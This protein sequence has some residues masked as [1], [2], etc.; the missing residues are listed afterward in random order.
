MNL[1]RSAH[2][3]VLGEIKLRAAT[4]TNPKLNRNSV[5]RSLDG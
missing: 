5:M 3:R 1:V 2:S 4:P